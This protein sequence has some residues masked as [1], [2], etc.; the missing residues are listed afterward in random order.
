MIRVR[1]ALEIARVREAVQT[2]HHDLEARV[3]ARTDELEEAQLQLL[4]RLGRAAEYRDDDTG[5][6]TRRVGITSGRLAETMGVSPGVSDMIQRAA[7]LHDV[8]KLSL[9]H[10]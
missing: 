9:I 7:P 8:G 1:N 6:H 2:S 3:R 4:A 10:I 5:D